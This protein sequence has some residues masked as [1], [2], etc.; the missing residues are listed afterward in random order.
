MLEALVTARNQV[1]EWDG[2]VATEVFAGSQQEEERL[3]ADPPAA[4]LCRPREGE[5]EV[6]VVPPNAPL[7]WHAAATL[8]PEPVSMIS[9][10]FR[11]NVQKPVKLYKLYVLKGR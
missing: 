2:E 4:M 9:Y 5:A 1:E 7:L 11:T 8:P 3:L 10:V 6:S